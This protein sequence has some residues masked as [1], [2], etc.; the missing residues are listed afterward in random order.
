MSDDYKLWELKQSAYFAEQLNFMIELYPKV[1]KKLEAQANI[2]QSSTAGVEDNPKG[3]NEQISTPEERKQA[4]YK[5]IDDF[6]NYG[7][8][9][10]V[11]NQEGHLKPLLDFISKGLD[12]YLDHFIIAELWATVKGNSYA[13]KGRSEIIAEYQELIGDAVR[14]GDLKAEIAIRNPNA[15]SGF[16]VIEYSP[17]VLN[18]IRDGRLGRAYVQYTI[19][20]DNFK[21]WLE[22]NNKYPLDNGCLLNAWFLGIKQEN[23]T[24][25]QPS[26]ANIEDN[27]KG[28]NER[29]LT[30]LNNK[31]RKK[32]TPKGRDRNEALLLIYELLEHMGINYLDELPTI[33]AWNI[34]A[35]GDFKSDLIKTLPKNSHGDIVLNGGEILDK[36]KF[37]TKYNRRFKKE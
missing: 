29:V 16:D 28:N 3:N 4:F 18:E 35:N 33:K 1:K 2:K 24:I 20:R 9:M 25:E 17:T 37:S 11:Q 30:P 13:N 19:S 7:T 6:D 34:I 36:N 8:P 27:T 22:S 5:A 14:S 32:L 15:L 21:S 31:P 12:R 26:T 23:K 10:P